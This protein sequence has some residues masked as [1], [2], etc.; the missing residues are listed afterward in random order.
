MPLDEKTLEDARKAR[1]VLV[2]L[3]SQ[4]AHARVDYHHAIKKLHAAGG[5]LR[6]IAD[7]LDLSHQ[8]VHQIVED[9]SDRRGVLVVPPWIKRSRR[10]DARHAKFLARLNKDAQQIIMVD[11]QDEAERLKHGYVGTE[12]LM[13]ALARSGT[14]A[15]LQLDVEAARSDVVSRVGEGASASKSRRPFTAQSKLAIDQALQTAAARN[16]RQLTAND[17]LLAVVS[18]EGTGGETL[19]ALGVTPERVRE[20]IRRYS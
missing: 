12:H 10:V 8:R 20:H 3:E 9:A 11:A 6:E 4:T 5:S 1:Q 17:L 16:E 14:T 2:D 15:W 19:Q 7:A 18:G 13:L